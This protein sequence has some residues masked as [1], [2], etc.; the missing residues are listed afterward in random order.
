ME[1][2]TMK[3]T[4]FAVVDARGEFKKSGRFDTGEFQGQREAESFRISLSNPEDYTVESFTEESQ[5]G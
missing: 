2:I 4:I 1:G 3:N 5:E